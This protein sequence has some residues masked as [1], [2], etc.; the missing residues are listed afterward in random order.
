MFGG[1]GGL[2]VELVTGDDDGG[3][4]G[5]FEEDTRLASPGKGASESGS[6]SEG[7]GGY[8]PSFG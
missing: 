4:G 7:G 5:E 3:G 1:P 6:D 8:M 2:R